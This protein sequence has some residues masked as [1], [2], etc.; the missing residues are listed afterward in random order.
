L[1]PHQFGPQKLPHLKLIDICASQTSSRAQIQISIPHIFARKKKK[2]E[3]KERKKSQRSFSKSLSSSFV[4]IIVNPPLVSFNNLESVTNYKI[5]LIF[6]SQSL[7]L[8]WVRN[9]A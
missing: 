8:M 3:K 4:T 7:L 1:A 2:G 6:F 9:V 5:F